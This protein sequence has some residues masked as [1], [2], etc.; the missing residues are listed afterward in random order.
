METTGY[1]LDSA[2][3]TAA[4]NVEIREGKIETLTY[5][6]DEGSNL[7]YVIPNTADTSTLT[8]RVQNSLEDSTG[9]SDAWTLAVDL[10]SVG[11]TDKA[12]HIQEIDNGEFEVY[13]GDN[14]VGKKPDNNNIIHLQYLRTN[15][16]NSNGMGSA[17][18]EGARVFVHSGS[19]VKVTSPASGG[20]FA[21]TS[22][23]IKFYA[24][25][26]YQA[27]DR[28]VTSRD[29]EAALLSEYSDIESVYVW[30]GQ[31]NDPPEYGKVFISLKPKSGLTVDETKKELIK[32][33]ILKKKKYGIS[34]S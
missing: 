26:T 8:V 16:P 22:K 34:K 33:D 2:G 1:T 28:S 31:D 14:I 12:Y 21:E 13:F 4:Q 10:N 9:Y 5:I 11:K 3:L 18:K 27:Q 29:Y 17:D 19:T 15:G 32:N 24:P 7:K 23:S 20:A 6:Y 30:G 25:K